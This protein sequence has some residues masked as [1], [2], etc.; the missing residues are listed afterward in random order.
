MTFRNLFASESPFVRSFRTTLTFLLAHRKKALLAWTFIIFF[1]TAGVSKL[2]IDLSVENFFPRD[3][4]EMVV[5]SRFNHLFGR[6][7]A[8]AVLL[9]ANKGEWN[10]E[11]LAA[12]DDLAAG[13]KGLHAVGDTF[14]LLD[15]PYPQ[16]IDD[17]EVSF[18]PLRTFLFPKNPAPDDRFQTFLG[19]LGLDGPFLGNFFS[20]AASS[21]VL[22]LRLSGS[23]VDHL[24]RMQATTEIR[25]YLHS[26][27]FRSR[28]DFTLSGLPVIRADGMVLIQN[29]QKLLLPIAI[30][31][32]TVFL[33]LIFGRWI[34][35]FLVVINVMVGNALVMGIMGY[36]GKAFSILSSVIPVILVTTGCCYGIQVLS[37]LRVRRG[38]RVDFSA[39]ARREWDNEFL[40]QVFTEMFQPMF[41]ANLTTVVGFMSLCITNMK[42][43]SEFAVI[44][45]GGV[46]IVFLLTM[47]YFPLLVASFPPPDPTRRQSWGFKKLKRGILHIAHL[48]VTYP[49]LIS[50]VLFSSLF[51]GLFFAAKVEVKSLV[52]DDYHQNSPFIRTIRRVEQT[53]LGILPMSVVVDVQKSH[54]VIL[55]HDYMEKAFRITQFL[56]RQP[57]VAKVDSPTDFLAKV[58]SM[59]LAGESNAAAFPTNN[60]ELSQVI[61]LISA[62]SGAESINTLIAKDL[63]ALQIPFR[64]K[65][66]DSKKAAAFI[67]RVETWIKS[68]EDAN[69]KIDLTGSTRM[70]QE[71][72]RSVFS[73]LLKSFSVVIGF[74]VVFL[75]LHFPEPKTMIAA[76]FGNII[77]T[78]W[79]I[80]VMGIIGVS[81]KP[82]TNTI[83]G[84]ALGLA[85]DNTIYFL[86]SRRQYG[87]LGFTLKKT[88]T[89]ALR[90][91]GV[92]MV[93]SSSAAILGF[94][95]LLF[96]EFEAQ[97]LIGL[98]LSFSVFMGLI[99][100]LFFIPALLTWLK[101]DSRES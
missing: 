7:D 6:D 51:V 62:G 15:V 57:E 31:I 64:I 65:D 27:P 17:S 95:A 86:E 75:V 4:P 23:S 37:R 70:I 99:F 8:I 28:F 59:L 74:T 44:T 56:R 69:T 66:L 40:V 76:F 52:F 2:D 9:A 82:S 36:S 85:L 94:L 63:S 3:C 87:A 97:Y 101:P 73:N 29:D 84:I 89:H 53:C 30:L 83:F 72:Y 19:T 18:E 88:I 96:S 12:L 77:P 67:E 78:I 60:S 90:R 35:V 39:Q 21:A 98:L 22:L 42:L 34:E 61:Q 41:L 50:I 46:V 11:S 45:S 55:R 100:D 10:T 26:S 71:S 43:V 54:H 91:C 92:G 49:R 80:G 13:L 58:Y 16:I 20:P 93:V 81:Y 79:I 1:L 24:G 14:S 25:E 33:Y 68:L 48:N 5:F 38:S 47:T 32:I